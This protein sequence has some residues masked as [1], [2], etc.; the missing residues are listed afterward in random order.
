MIGPVV[1]RRG[2]LTSGTA[3]G[4]WLV[5][6]AVLGARP[7]GLN[8]AKMF[9]MPPVRRETPFQ[10]FD[11]EPAREL[12]DGGWR[13]N[14][15]DIPMPVIKGGG[16]SY[17]NAKAGNAQGAAAS[18]F[19][20]TAWPLVTLPHDWAI[21]S[22]PD[23]DEN[24]AQGYRKRGIAWYR[25]TIRFEPADKGRYFELQFDGI[26]TNAT[27][28]FNGN[29][30]DHNWSGYNSFCL[31]VTAMA[32]FGDNLNSLVVRVDADKMEGWWYEGAGIYRNAWLARR[33]A[34]YILTDGVHADPRCDA[35][36][37]WFVPV[38]VDIGNAGDTSGSVT[39][40]AELRDPQGKIVARASTDSSV[41]PL[42]TARAQLRL[43]APDPSLWSVAKPDLY[44]V[45]TR[46]LRGGRTIDERHLRTG[47]RTIRFDPDQGFFLNGSHVKLKGVCL[48]QDHAGVGVAVP[49][50][51]WEFRLRRMKQFGVNAI[52]FTHNAVAREV[53]DLCDELGFLVMAE[54]RNFN[55]SPVYLEQLE[56]LVRRDRNRPSVIM[57]SV[58]NEEPMEGTYAGKQM[59]RRMVEKIRELDTSRPT[60]AALNEGVFASENVGQIVD[61][62]GFNYQ[63]GAY[64][65]FHSLHPDRPLT[66]SEDTSAF[67]TRGEWISD[68]SKHI[69]TSYDE[70]MAPWGKTQRQA[71]TA[72]TARPFVA[73]GFVWTGFDYHGEP[74]PFEWPSNSSMFGI[75]DL[76]GFPKM[77]A[78]IRA[79]Y[80]KEE[81]VLELGPHWNWPGSE[82]KP[83]TIMAATNV[84]RVSLML[85]GRSIGELAVDQAVMPHW[86][87]P[88]A[89]GR[90]EA[91]GFRGG[92]EVIRTAVETT[93]APVRLRITPWRDAMAGDGE[94]VQ[95][96]TVDAI[97][98]AGRHVPTANLDLQFACSG[99]T[100]IGLGNGDPTDVSLELGN[101]RRMFNGLAQVIVRASPG[102]GAVVLT[103][104]AI[105]LGKA[106][107]RV[108]VLARVPR[109]RV[110]IEKATM[111]IGGWRLSPTFAERPDPA[112]VPGPNWAS[113][114]EE[115]VRK[116]EGDG[117]WTIFTASITPYRSMQEGN[118]ELVL[119]DVIGR[120]EI[121]VDGKLL[122][123]K[124]DPAATTMRVLLG[125]A[126][127]ERRITL[128]LQAEPG[129][130]AGVGGG[131]ILREAGASDVR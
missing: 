29:L 73:G 49:A 84:E 92:R 33:S 115:G 111:K 17:A 55:P 39:I 10:A 11:I 97:D 116:P 77:A 108:P 26:A 65:R 75:L 62:V 131:R 22:P 6:P 32:R 41:E 94:D 37:Q 9:P 16:W 4:A 64:D 57:W 95:P 88:Y 71:W 80:W 100:I 13:F 35:A 59:V 103:A 1:S 74:T 114:N 91:V 20:D 82:G 12:L 56:W 118:A 18:D 126:R 128:V 5:Q 51:L 117:P 70:E 21:L 45:S 47:F 79:A 66:S 63:P 76:C 87:V 72:I 98:S 83:I 101:A 14:L 104:S 2:L 86:Q 93:S 48:H 130:V 113:V 24:I 129:S 15:G 127:G 112:T 110:A 40:E 31:D 38:T 85:N 105:G 68:P 27:I 25:R 42:M 78:H 23:K 50:A 60:T 107:V 81:P 19:D 52:R 7:T 99:G 34:L 61:V 89:P 54:N 30:I 8:D 44:T 120:A 96:F 123:K 90:L 28:W 122:A 119:G 67:M 125:P 106:S 124:G 58:F 53:M 36:G 3:M 109:R 46:L 69:S 102:S 43:V 121:W